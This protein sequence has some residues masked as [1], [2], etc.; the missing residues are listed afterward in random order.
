M[1]I[2][3]G[4]QFV[5]KYFYISHIFCQVRQALDFIH[6]WDVEEMEGDISRKFFHVFIQFNDV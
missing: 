4:N 1:Y 3:L 2:L 6:L 5:L